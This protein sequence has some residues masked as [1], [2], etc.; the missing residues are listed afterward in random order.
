MRTGKL[1]RHTNAIAL[2]ILNCIST[3]LIKLLANGE[4]KGRCLNDSLTCLISQP[5]KLG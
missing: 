4:A 1:L 5:C 2:I 3:K